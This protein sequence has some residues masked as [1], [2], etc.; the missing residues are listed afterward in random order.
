LFVVGIGKDDENDDENDDS[1]GGS[2]GVLS[3]GDV[4]GLGSGRRD[5]DSMPSVLS[6]SMA[7]TLNETS[8]LATPSMGGEWMGLNLFVVLGQASS[9]RKRLVAPDELATLL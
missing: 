7:D 9:N 5:H 2:G 3:E 4:M 1:R 8:G 6:S